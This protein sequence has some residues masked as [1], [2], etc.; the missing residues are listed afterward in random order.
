[1]IDQVEALIAI[2]VNTG[3]YVGKS[4]KLEDTIVKTNIEAAKEIARQIRLR[5]LGGIIVCDFIDME[6][7]KNRL[8]VTQTLEEALRSDRSPSK[9]LQ[10][11]DFGLVAI[12]RKRVKQ[13][14]LK[15]LCE[16]CTHC[17]GSGMVKSPQTV[18]YEI[19]GEVKKMAKFLDNKE[20]TLRVNPEVA[21]ALKTSEASVI[22]EIE[23]SLRKEVIVK[24]DSL[25]HQEHF[26][27][28]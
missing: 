13:S 27:I 15:V 25:L 14:L 12:T 6:D 18:C 9:I 4:N 19:Q 7:R 8:K 24:S 1:V 10:F 26:D 17:A 5:D 23:S 16:P 28:F 2:D 22:N 21:K 20:I 11:N 3:K